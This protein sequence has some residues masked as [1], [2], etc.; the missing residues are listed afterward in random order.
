MDWLEWKQQGRAG[1][2]LLRFW[3]CPSSTVAA[4]LT[5]HSILPFTRDAGGGESRAAQESSRCSMLAAGP[6]SLIILV[7][8]HR[9]T[10]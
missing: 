8:Y 6:W 10:A 3:A 1:L 7:S 5:S 4:G 9:L 2:S